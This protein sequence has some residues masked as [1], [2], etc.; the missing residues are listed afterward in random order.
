VGGR[1]ATVIDVHAHVRVPEA[2]NL[3]KDRIA[4][5]GRAGDAQQASP[6]G[7]SNIHND[8]GKRLAD[9]DEMG[10]DTQV[11]SVNP[12]WY[13]ADE[14]LSRDVIQIQNEKIAEL[15]SA[16]PK[17]FAGFGGVALQHPALAAGQMENGVKKL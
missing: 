17:R 2:W 11:V 5:E 9:M 16:H 15:C 7:P 6:D 14:G 3:V 12:F 8:A 10:I 13:W 4:R 1:R